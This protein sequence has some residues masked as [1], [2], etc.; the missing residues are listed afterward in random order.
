M[1]NIA[2]GGAGVSLH[3]VRGEFPR[4]SIISPSF[5]VVDL[6]QT[7]GRVYRN[8]MKTPCV[9]HVLIA[10]GTIEEA[11]GES[12]RKKMNSLDALLDGV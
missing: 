8:G 3:D 6:V 4:A 9:Q 2:A 7:L 5:N 10:E 1:A 12:L 11:I